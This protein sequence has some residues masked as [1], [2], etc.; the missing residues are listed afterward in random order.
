MET[1]CRSCHD[2][3]DHAWIVAVNSPSVFHAGSAKRV[4]WVKN[5]ALV[6][7][8]PHHGSTTWWTGD[9]R[10]LGQMTGRPGGEAGLVRGTKGSGRRSKLTLLAQPLHRTDE[11]HAQAPPRPVHGR[12]VH[13]TLVGIT[14]VVEQTQTW[15]EEGYSVDGFNRRHAKSGANEHHGGG[16]GHAAF[17]EVAPLDGKPA[18]ARS[19]TRVRKVTLSTPPSSSFAA[20]TTPSSSSSRGVERRSS[21][22]LWSCTSSTASAPS[23]VFLGPTSAAHAHAPC[24]VPV[25]RPAHRGAGA[26]MMSTS[27]SAGG[28]GLRNSIR[29]WTM[30]GGPILPLWSR[31]ASRSWERVGHLRAQPQ[32]AGVILEPGKVQVEVS[33]ALFRP[34]QQRGEHS[35]TRSCRHV[36]TSGRAV[37][38][39]STPVTA[40]HRGRRCPS[41][42]GLQVVRCPDPSRPASRRC[43]ARV[44]PNGSLGPPCG[45]GRVVV[46]QR[47]GRRTRPPERPR[48]T[49]WRVEQRVVGTVL[50]PLELVQGV[51]WM[52]QV[53]SCK[54]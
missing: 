8:L 24:F 6:F 39:F 30:Q 47:R 10:V 20:H 12:V 44:Q 28:H 52:P 14:A 40:N 42:L 36:L 16:P 43:W 49:G 3:S 11:V 27:G 51:L 54:V 37:L 29:R 15:R 9:H 45:R 25:M 46:R 2:P 19:C 17:V 4:A 5:R 23:G 50:E 33:H 7:R 41:L 38:G 18:A 22:I 35:V 13:V 1:C 53:A 31:Q 21:T 26:V 32:R 34:E 48:R